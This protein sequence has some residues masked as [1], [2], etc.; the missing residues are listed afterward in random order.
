ML[1]GRAKW[2]A[3]CLDALTMEAMPCIDGMEKLAR[4]YNVRWLIFET[5]CQEL[6]T[7]W[8]ARRNQRSVIYPHLQ[9]MQVLKLHFTAFK[10]DFASRE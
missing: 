5:D 1:A 10:L 2:Y 9:R 8:D 3:N 4:K 7:L 6:I